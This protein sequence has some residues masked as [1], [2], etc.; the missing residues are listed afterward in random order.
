MA[1]IKDLLEYANGEFVKEKIESPRTDARVLL[2]HCLNVDSLYLIL[3]LDNEVTNDDV[4]RYKRIVEER[5]DRKP[6]AYITGT[7]E[8]MGLDF[9]V[10]EHTLIPRPET[11]LL[12]EHITRVY[13]EKPSLS[14]LEIGVGCGCI[15][16]AIAKELKNANI[17][18][19]DISEKALEVAK[20]NLMKHEV[21]DRVKFIFSDLLLSVEDMD[22]DIIVSNP[23]YIRTKDL[24]N[25][26]KDITMY[27][28]L[29]ALDGGED[30]L[31]FYRKIIK[32]SASHL[33]RKGLLI[34]E[35]G[36]DQ[37]EDVMKIME[38]N[39]YY[40]IRTF[41]DLAGLDRVVVGYMKVI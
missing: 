6:V 7:K 4:D 38:D 28:P 27:E 16:I 32:E 11:E 26:Q 36:H 14:I 25:L 5:I 19:V 33:N 21:E 8:F 40:G 31:Y 37:A 34:L 29:K 24:D 2:A 15:S 12:V 23:P 20:E 13:K 9:K 39:E 18:G 1:S 30:G 3:H 10:N 17:I 35:I 22:F 41:K